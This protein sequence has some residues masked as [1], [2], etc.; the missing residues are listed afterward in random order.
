MNVEVAIRAALLIPVLNVAYHRTKMSVNERASR[1]AVGRV[2]LHRLQ[3]V[4]QNVVS[5]MAKAGVYYSHKAT[6]FRHA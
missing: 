5:S 2:P 1:Q 4:A 6:S 3:R